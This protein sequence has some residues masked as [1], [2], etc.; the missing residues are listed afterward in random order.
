MNNYLTVPTM[1][2]IVQRLVLAFFTLFFCICLSA[3][4]ITLTAN[5]D[6]TYAELILDNV[7]YL[8]VSNIDSIPVINNSTYIFEEG[9]PELVKFTKSISLD[10]LDTLSFQIVDYDFYEVNASIAA[11][12]GF[13]YQNSNDTNR[14]KGTCFNENKFYPDTV[15]KML[16]PYQIRNS[17]FQPF[18]ILP[19][20]Y[21][22]VTKKLR[23]YT[24]LKIKLYSDTTA[25]SNLA[26]NATESD[27]GDSVSADTITN[28]IITTTSSS[29]KSLSVESLTI[30]SLSSSSSSKTTTSASTSSKSM[31]I[32]APEDYKDELT[33][34]IQWKKQLGID[35]YLVTFSDDP[36]STQIKNN[37]SDYYSN[38]QI[39]YALLV[40][41]NDLIPGY[42]STYGISDYYYGLQ[43]NSDAY[44]DLCVGRFPAS[45][46]DDLQNIISKT[47][48]YEMA[49]DSSDW[50]TTFAGIASDDDGGSSG[51]KGESDYEHIQNIASEFSNNK[52][53]A[54]V[55][56]EGASSNPSI[57]DV[58]NTGCDYLFYTGHGNEIRWASLTY[59]TDSIEQLT[60]NY[61]YPIII[62]VACSNGN[63]KYSG[64]F[65]ETFMCA[66]I[67]NKP[68]GSVSILASS[69]EQAWA[70]PMR[71]QDNIADGF[72][73]SDY[74]YKLGD[75]I[76]NGFTDMINTYGTTGVETAYTWI[77]FGDPSL[78][79]W[80]RQ[81]SQMECSIPD[82]FD[83]AASDF[84]VEGPDSAF[85]SIVCNN[86]LIDVKE[87]SDGYANLERGSNLIND[88]VIVTVS[89]KNCIPYI[90]KIAPYSDGSSYYNV[91]QIIV[92]N[93]DE[94]STVNDQWFS[95]D[96]VLKNYGDVTGKNIRV[97]IEST[98]SLLEF[99]ADTLYLDSLAGK[100]IDTLT[101]FYART[102][103][104]INDQGI[105]SVTVSVIDEKEEYN[106]NNFDI[107][108][109]AP[110]LSTATL[111]INN[112]ETDSTVILDN[113]TVT[114]SAVIS[115][116]GHAPSD[117]INF[118][119]TLDNVLCSYQSDNIINRVIDSMS[120]DTINFLV[121]LD[122]NCIAGLSFE[123]SITIDDSQ[124]LQFLLYYLSNPIVEIG[125]ASQEV[126]EYP[127]YNYYK[128]SRS[129]MIYYAEEISR[130][131]VIIDSIAFNIASVPYSSNK[132]TLNNF[133]ILFSETS[134]TDFSNAY[135]E[136]D[137]STIVFSED[138][139]TMTDEEG[140][141]D[142]D[143]EDYTFSAQKNLMIEIIWGINT[144][145]TNYSNSY[146]VYSHI[147]DNITTA[148]G[149]S[150]VYYP[151]TWIGVDKSCPDI[152][153]Y[154]EEANTKEVYIAFKS[155][156]SDSLFVTMGTKDF[157]V[158]VNDSELLHLPQ[159][160]YSF[161]Y[162]SSSNNEKTAYNFSVEKNK[163]FLINEYA[164][165]TID[166]GSGDDTEEESGGELSVIPSITHEI[167]I[168]YY[169]NTLIIEIEN[170]DYYTVSVFDLNGREVYLKSN[171]QYSNSIDMGFLSQGIYIA[172]VY[173]NH[174][175]K[176]LKIT[177]PL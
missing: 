1:N 142:I 18:W 138:E 118:T 85:V 6:A 19:L 8:N 106:Y 23:I 9:Y 107:T 151:A 159:G 66:S 145:T 165:T 42:S 76:F 25:T 51:D 149:Y 48:Q 152:R 40:G 32:L 169:A 74:T 26:L 14:V 121:S 96:V 105:V 116:T 11:T 41:T 87:I 111:L 103:T 113:N 154:T 71:G 141:F 119:F 67:N 147:T 91:N 175:R 29:T 171:L 24:Y 110:V 22:P 101:S 17:Y 125:D 136:A 34:F 64:N 47:I 98:D 168:R 39:D 2:K 21:N 75:V 3:Q 16:A 95:I 115:N 7:H 112:S 46:S 89:K 37:I 124:I 43:A 88:S 90:K 97:A 58:I 153:L 54:K 30:K 45:S 163:T 104:E 84:I 155:D 20:Q 150:D 5:S 73:E 123:G 86:T 133:E 173:N 83:V 77:L 156:Y 148:F 139:F 167:T 69:I 38:Y 12:T 52:F 166:N 177:T 126:A 28:S 132:R 31:L 158:A 70:P 127:F 79:F 10:G 100:S 35:T 44:A 99:K 143:I 81:P 65:A 56:Y 61:K 63:I 109:N 162:Y 108:I 170:A 174:F 140:W 4:E 102:K 135:I 146:S 57:S 129:Q 68:T 176:S 122:S 130:S 114:L 161:Y 60:N 78:N 36:T 94:K 157:A 120:N 134:S 93:G 27:A 117:S 15:I 50:I 62:D 55:L 72:F 59:T 131:E 160:N 137:S 80:T 33:S 164:D 53:D 144:I 172:V 128:S 82:S 49:A 92:C 13:I